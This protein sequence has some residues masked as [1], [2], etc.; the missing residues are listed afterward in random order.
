MLAFVA[1]RGLTA[2]GAPFVP[3][4]ISG[5]ITL[6]GS[7]GALIPGGADVLLAMHLLGLTSSMHPGPGQTSRISNGIVAEEPMN[8]LGTLLGCGSPAPNTKIW[9]SEPHEGEER[10]MTLPSGAS[11]R[12]ESK[13]RVALPVAAPALSI[14]LLTGYLLQEA[15]YSI[16]LGAPSGGCIIPAHVASDEGSNG[17]DGA[18]W[19]RLHL[20]LGLAFFLL[21]Q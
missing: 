5:D 17:F 15:F 16:E 10:A 8:A 14:G 4:R 2:L 20:I 11:A 21:R 19:R 18:D 6:D 13:F 3:W 1:Y 7:V 9:I 12:V